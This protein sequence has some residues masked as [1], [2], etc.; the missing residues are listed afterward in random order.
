MLDRLNELAESVEVLYVEDDADA[1]EA[2]IKILSRFIKNLRVAKNGQ[3]GLE[4]FKARSAH[5]NLVLTD[6]S[7][8]V[9][10]GLDMLRS[11]K[12]IKPNQHAIVIS[13]HNDT[14][15]L[16]S[17][18]DI[19]IE[20]FLIKPVQPEK[21]FN[22]FMKILTKI[23]NDKELQKLQQKSIDDRLKNAVHLSYEIILQNI[24][25]AAAIIDKNDAILSSNSKFCS[26][27]SVDDNAIFNYVQNIFLDWKEE[28]IELYDG[29][30]E[31]QV[32]CE[33]DEQEYRSS[34]S[35]LILNDDLSDK[36]IIVFFGVMKKK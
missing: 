12:E 32:S 30:V 29:L 17:A 24:P 15:N 14:K 26:C 35:R 20:H 16:I 31:I 9:M 2:T 6:I 34:V 19:G 33:D 5:I 7:M 28:A 36:Y 3:E 13:A 25:F 23:Q 11:M 10:N 27:F 1:S 4:V 22:T 18:I 21:M 8:P